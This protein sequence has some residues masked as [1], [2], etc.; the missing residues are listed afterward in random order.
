MYVVIQRVQAVLTP[1]LL[2]PKYKH[3]TGVG[4]H[5]YAA[6]EACF[7]LLGGKPAG[8]TPVVYSSNEGW[9]HWWLR[10]EDG[11]I[12]DPT[13]DQFPYVFPY[14]LGRGNGFLTKAPSKRASEIM[15]RI[16]SGLDN[17]LALEPALEH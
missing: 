3:K 12:C 9:T 8:W 15:K 1:D 11:R 7:H 10:H 5:C 4:G 13:A 17:R 6:S 14:A 2:K 16:N